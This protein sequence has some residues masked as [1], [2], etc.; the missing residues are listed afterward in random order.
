MNEKQ[1]IIARALEIAI[2][3]TKADHTW[4]RRDKQD[5]LIINDPLYTTMK[6]VMYII[7]DESLYTYDKSRKVSR[8]S[9]AE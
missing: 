6:S 7:S 1:E 8:G 2:T 3:L 9:P 4:L 5:D